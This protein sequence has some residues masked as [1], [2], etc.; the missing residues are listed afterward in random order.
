MTASLQSH[1]FV[2]QTAIVSDLPMTVA[3]LRMIPLFQGLTQAELETVAGVTTTHKFDQHFTLF[4]YGDDGDSMYFVC[5]GK[6]KFFHENNT[7][8]GFELEEIGAGAFLG[9]VATLQGGTRTATA[10]ITQDMIALELKRNDLLKLLEKHPGLALKLLGGMAERLKRSGEQIRFNVTPHIGHLVEKPMSRQDQA[11][12][13]LARRC[14]SLN[15]IGLN[16]LLIAVWM[17][18]THLLGGKPFDGA[19]FN[20]LALLI[21]VESIFI[22]A[23]VLNSQHRQSDADARR[24][25]EEHKAIINAAAALP[26]LRK[27]VDALRAD[28]QK[29]PKP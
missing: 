22:T 21:G 5:S 13:N 27:E 26:L 8:E 17:L 25:S 11:I 12:H 29:R 15:L 2:P 23:I 28:L 20:A 1:L 10:R 6:V 9:E 16:F 24:D 4:K 14:G 3:R 7:E 18:V 19:A